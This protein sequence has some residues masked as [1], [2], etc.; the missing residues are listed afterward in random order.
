VRRAVVILQTDAGTTCRLRDAR[1]EVLA[2]N[3]R[4]GFEADGVQAT[5]TAV[6]FPIDAAVAPNGGVYV[7]RAHRVRRVDAAAGTT[8]AR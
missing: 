4:D 8:V 1:L 2:G 5:S 7:V 6:G 3:G